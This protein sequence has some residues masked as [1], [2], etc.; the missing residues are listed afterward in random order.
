MTLGTDP[1]MPD[2][3]LDGLSDY[4][5][6][7]AAGTNPLLRDFDGDGIPDGGDPDPLS[8]DAA[9]LDGDGL[10]DAWETRW[11]GSTNATDSAEADTGGDGFS[12][13]ANLLTGAN[14][15][16][17]AC[18][19]TASGGAHTFT[20]TALPGATEYAATVT[21][22]GAAVWSCLT[23]VCLLSPS[24][25]TSPRPSTRSRSRRTGA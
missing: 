21:R 4:E 1:S 11:F 9:D 8:A 5:E 12:D 19:V 16:F 13:R 10:P 6:V 15:A 23:N 14:P 2:T 3:D 20:W 25:A 18:A 17:A 22:G 24:R 7:A